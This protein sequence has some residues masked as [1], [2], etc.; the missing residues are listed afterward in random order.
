MYQPRTEAAANAGGIF[1]GL[2]NAGVDRLTG[3]DLLGDI[4]GGG[5]PLP[6]LARRRAKRGCAEGTRGWCWLVV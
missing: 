4:A 3:N 6:A 1:G 5:Q 2:V